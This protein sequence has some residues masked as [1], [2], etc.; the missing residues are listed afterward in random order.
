MGFQRQ[1]ELEQ[2]DSFDLRRERVIYTRS[3]IP[4]WWSLFSIPAK[5]W[6]PD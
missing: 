6:V 1:I 4:K 3:V 2:R 5:D